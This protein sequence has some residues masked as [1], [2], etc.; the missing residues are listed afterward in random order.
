[1]MGVGK[2]GLIGG[3]TD[4]GSSWPNVFTIVPERGS[5]ARS[6]DTFLGT[7][8]TLPSMKLWPETT[9]LIENGSFYRYDNV[10]I[11]RELA[12]EEILFD[13]RANEVA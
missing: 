10:I 4:H 11:V 3:G 7:Y 8:A 5:M 13:H 12:T 6:L 2:F 9:C 1:M